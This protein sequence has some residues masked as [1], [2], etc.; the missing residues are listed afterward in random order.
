MYTFICTYNVHRRSLP[1][2]RTRVQPNTRQT[3]VF[4]RT[5]PNTTVKPLSNTPNTPNTAER[6]FSVDK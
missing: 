5:L 1:S 2:T 6:A 4:C 3:L